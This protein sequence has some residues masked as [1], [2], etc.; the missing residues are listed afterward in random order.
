MQY[1]D[2]HGRNITLGKKIGTGGEGAVYEIVG[3]AD[4]V[5]KIYHQPATQEKAAKLAAM[6]QL[7]TPEILKFAAWPKATLHPNRSGSTY[8]LI[9]PRIK[10]SHEIHELYSP[11]HR[12]TR[13]PRADWRFLLRTA[14]NCAAAFSTLHDHN[15]VIGDVNQGNVFVSAHAIVNLI[16][17]VRRQL[18]RLPERRLERPGVGADWRLGVN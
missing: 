11:A 4:F 17:C 18:V 7:A 2:Q 3:V 5:A 15:I 12:K 1:V 8:G 9:L 13:F 14:R 16:D 10:E 6:A